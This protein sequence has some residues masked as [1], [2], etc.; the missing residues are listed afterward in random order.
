LNLPI[1]VAARSRYRF[2][3]DYPK[4]SFTFRR[5]LLNGFGDVQFEFSDS[6]ANSA[7]L[8]P[9]L[10]FWRDRVCRRGQGGWWIRSEDDE[11][12][13]TTFACVSATGVDAGPS[14]VVMEG[15]SQSVHLP[16]GPINGYPRSLCGNPNNP[17]IAVV[18][19][20]VVQ[21]QNEE[22]NPDAQDQ[23]PEIDHSTSSLAIYAIGRSV[24]NKMTA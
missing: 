11:A 18:L 14:G 13:P 24:L 19:G 3:E 20:R 22:P 12:F 17:T 10:S 21:N 2:L 16:R 9:R 7:V 4:K 15:F 6:T 1:R 8:S 23:H 5:G